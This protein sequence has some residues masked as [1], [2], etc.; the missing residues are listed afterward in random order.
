MHLPLLLQTLACLGRVSAARCNV[1][2]STQLKN[3]LLKDY[4]ADVRPVATQKP[5]RLAL[6]IKVYAL[7]DM[8]QIAGTMT[9]NLWL[10]A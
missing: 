3:A 6:G 2:T 5:L 9:L 10:L 8:D 7:V 1:L 4:R